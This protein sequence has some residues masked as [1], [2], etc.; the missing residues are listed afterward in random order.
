[1]PFDTTTQTRPEGLNASRDM[2]QTADAALLMVAAPEQVQARR[3]RYEALKLAHGVRPGKPVE[4]SPQEAEAERRDR[5]N[6]PSERF[7]DG[8]EVERWAGPG[9]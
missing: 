8:Y 9:Q 3:E 7:D 2:S 1:M 6:E 4:L 5:Y